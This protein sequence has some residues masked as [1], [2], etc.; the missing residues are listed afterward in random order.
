[1][2]A[3]KAID[4]AKGHSEFVGSSLNSCIRDFDSRGS[5]QLVFYYDIHQLSVW[6]YEKT[7]ERLWGTKDIVGHWPLGE[8]PAEVFD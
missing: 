5:N 3:D 2:T 7:T 4:I 6:A 8:Y 1:M